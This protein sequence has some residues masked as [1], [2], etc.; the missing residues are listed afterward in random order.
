[1]KEPRLTLFDEGTG[2]MY[3]TT[4]SVA[5]EALKEL[6]TEISKRGQLTLYE[7]KNILKRYFYST[8][9]NDYGVLDNAIGFISTGDQTFKLT[10]PVLV[11]QGEYGTELLCLHATVYNAA[12]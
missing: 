1:M 6:N 5:K 4:L 10:D 9:L 3:E 11:R 2:Q 7:Y 12:E 8:V